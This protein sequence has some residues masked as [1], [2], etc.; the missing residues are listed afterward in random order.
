[1]GA[2]INAANKD[3]V[4]DSAS[5]KDVFPNLIVRL[6]G[7][8]DVEDDSRA[9]FLQINPRLRKEQFAADLDSDLQA[10]NRV[11]DGLRSGREI[12]SIKS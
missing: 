12:F 6:D 2:I 11:R 7:I 10:A 1:M 8:V 3:T 5:D 4:F 9:F